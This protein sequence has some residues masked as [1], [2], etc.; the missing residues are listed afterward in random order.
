[1][2][3]IKSVVRINANDWT[4]FQ[5]IS[6]MGFKKGF[7]NRK[8]CDYYFLSRIH[9]PLR[10][11]GTSGVKRALADVDRFQGVTVH[12]DLFLCNCEHWVSYWV[13]GEALSD[14]AYI[15]GRSGRT[16]PKSPI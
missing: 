15:L 10:Y 4:D 8:F 1:M 11:P 6:H 7:V 14:Q 2:S 13:S 16:G 3:Y 5:V 9:R 12:Y